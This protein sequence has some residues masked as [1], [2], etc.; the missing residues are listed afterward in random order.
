MITN[1]DILRVDFDFCSARFEHN[2]SA[3]FEVGYRCFFFFFCRYTTRKQIPLKLIST[4]SIFYA[5]S[6][7]LWCGLRCSLRVRAI[8]Q[9]LIVITLGVRLN[10]RKRLPDQTR[11]KETWVNNKRCIYYLITNMQNLLKLFFR[12]SHFKLV[13]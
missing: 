8:F 4:I 9:T 5:L 1:I 12:F 11:T 7:Q 13:S 10:S 6:L 2:C 3:S